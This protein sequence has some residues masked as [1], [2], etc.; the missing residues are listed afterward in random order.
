MQLYATRRKLNNDLWDINN[1]RTLCVDCHK[2]TET[3]GHKTK[4]LLKK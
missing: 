3:Y 2:K 4:K 1:G